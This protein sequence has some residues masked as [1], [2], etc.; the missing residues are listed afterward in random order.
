MAKKNAS[1]LKVGKHLS[2][3]MLKKRGSTQEGNLLLSSLTNLITQ[4][5][6]GILA[7]SSRIR[8]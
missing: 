6:T 2:N 4:K 5:L 1:F 8:N 7:E 3:E